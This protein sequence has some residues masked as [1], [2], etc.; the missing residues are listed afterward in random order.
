ME[1]GYKMLIYY[2]G[3]YE[4]IYGVLP[5]DNIRFLR[6]SDDVLEDG[7]SSRF[8]DFP[9]EHGYVVINDGETGNLLR[10]LDK[11][12][13]KDEYSELILLD[14]EFLVG[15]GKGTVLEVSRNKISS[16]DWFGDTEEYT[17]EEFIDRV[18]NF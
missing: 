2:D 10:V 15:E 16:F 5:A 9:Y 13:E 12:P 14:G 6:K 7:F 18:N 17:I 4:N 11:K 1:I 8:I 3:G